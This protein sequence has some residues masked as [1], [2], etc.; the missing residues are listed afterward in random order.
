M[1]FGF[2]VFNTRFLIRC[3]HSD[4]KYWK[5]FNYNLFYQALKSLK[6]SICL[7]KKYQFT[8]NSFFLGAMIYIIYIISLKFNELMQHYKYILF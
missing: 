6:F 5:M 8:Q 2:N 1:P 3:I 7:H 4:V